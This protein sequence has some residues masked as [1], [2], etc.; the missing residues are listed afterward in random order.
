M[1]TDIEI[2]HRY[3]ESNYIS[4]LDQGGFLK[5]ASNYYFIF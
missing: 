5:N 4:V 3:V 2:C 1:L